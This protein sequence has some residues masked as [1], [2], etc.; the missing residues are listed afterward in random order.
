MVTIPF[1]SLHFRLY[2]SGTIICQVCSVPTATI[3]D[4]FRPK[5]SIP[6]MNGVREKYD[7]IVNQ[8]C[9][10]LIITID[11]RQNYLFILYQ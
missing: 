4:F 2:D 3:F 11:V 9:R 5:Q 6:I 8:T 10:K 7:E 1:R